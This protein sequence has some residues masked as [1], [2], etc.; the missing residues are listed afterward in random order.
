MTPSEIFDGGETV[1]APV[2]GDASLT[3]MNLGDSAAEFTLGDDTREV[4]ARGARAVSG[5]GI[6]TVTSDEPFALGVTLFDTQ[7]LSSYPVL[8]TGQQIEG[9][10][11]YTR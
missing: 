3:V 9:F 1:R 6:V 10:T 11:V 4:P 2:L 7:S 8:G 5:T